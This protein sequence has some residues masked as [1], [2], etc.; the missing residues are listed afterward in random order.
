MH[1]NL[2]PVGYN[3]YL[4][5]SYYYNVNPQFEFHSGFLKILYTGTYVRGT[6]PN[7]LTPLITLKHFYGYC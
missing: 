1:Q 7:L 2:S 4:G 6:K 3:Y 5:I